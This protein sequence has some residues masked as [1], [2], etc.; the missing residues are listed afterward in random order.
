RSDNCSVR[1][2]W[3]NSQAATPMATTATTTSTRT[4]GF[5]CSLRTGTGSRPS[6]P[7]PRLPGCRCT[8]PTRAGPVRAPGVCCRPRPR[9]RRPPRRGTV[10][11][12]VGIAPDSWGVWFPSDPLQ[13]PWQRYLDEVAQA[14]YEYT[15]LGP[16]G[17]LPTDPATL[18]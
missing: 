4:S 13:T 6:R 8:S 5:M 1:R 10:R 16:Y 17:Y 14:G 15:E 9:H 3:R 2:F 7:A 18:R 12:R 11:L